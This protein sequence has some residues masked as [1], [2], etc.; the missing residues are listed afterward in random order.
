MVHRMCCN[1]ILTAKNVIAYVSAHCF[2][3]QYASISLG[4]VQSGTILQPVPDR[5]CVATNATWQIVLVVLC[6]TMLVAWE[7]QKKSRMSLASILER[8]QNAL[9]V[10][11]AVVGMSII[12][13]VMC[14]RATKRTPPD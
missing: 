12:C 6:P 4:E 8:A 10:D 13:L 1:H 3:I 14:D 9:A 7:R 5:P 2:D 11:E